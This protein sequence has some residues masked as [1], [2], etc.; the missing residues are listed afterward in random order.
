MFDVTL[1]DGAFAHALLYPAPMTRQ[2]RERMA[3]GFD[4]AYNEFHFTKALPKPF[5]QG[6]PV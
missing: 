3:R 6:Y 1:D 5:D 2:R 4:P